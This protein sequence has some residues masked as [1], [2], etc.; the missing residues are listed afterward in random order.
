MHVT[1]WAAAQRED[2]ELDAVLQWLEAKMKMDLRTLLWEHISSEEGKVIWRNHQNFTVLQSTLYLHSTPKGENE[3]LLLFVMPKTHW[4]AALNGCHQDAGHQGHDCTL[5]LLQECFWWP[6]MAKQMRQV[7]R[8]CKHC[9]Q[10]EGGTPK[11]PL[12]PIVATAP[13]DLLH[14]DFTSIETM[15]ELKQSP[16]VANVL[17]LQDHFTKHILAYVTPNQTVKTVTKFLYG[18]Y[19]SIFGAPA[20]LLSDRGTSFTSSIIE[21]LCKI[22]GIK[23]LLTTSYHPQTNGLVER[24]HQTI[25]CMIGKLGEDKKGDWPSHF[26]EIAHVYNATWSAVTGYSPHYLMFRQRPRLPVDFFFPTIGSNEAP[27][28]GASTKS[29]DVYV[30]SIRDRLR[31][32]LWE[33]QA[34]S[35]TEACQQKW[36]YDRKI[37]AVNLKPGDLVLVKADAWMGKRKTKDR[38]EEET[39]EVVHQITAD[40]P[41]Y[42][43]TNQHGWSQ[44]LH[45]NWLLLVASEIGVPLCMSSCHTWDRCTSPTPHKTT[46]VRGD[47]KRMPQEKSGKAVTQWPT[48]K[49]SLGWKNGKLQLIPWMSTRASTEDGWRPQVKWFG[50]KP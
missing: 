39:W 31:T 13:L 16:R 45:Q 48:S 27:M 40:I 22:L 1:N 41:S 3:D 5:S 38:W 7:I 24:S 18:G 10:Y 11:A 12:C 8:S 26:A 2:P 43:V 4:T 35:T 44:V 15:L 36:Y 29:V 14:I 47:E 33:A 23:W 32:T 37:G 50:C 17:V 25:M 46:S 9:L 6:G 20:R 49:A 30:A 34:Q 28:R 42:K 21:E 19:I